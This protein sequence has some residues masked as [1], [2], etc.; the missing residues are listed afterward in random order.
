VDLGLGLEGDGAGF[1][2]ALRVE[3]EL[4]VGVHQCLECAVVGAPLAQVDPVV[5]H[6]DLGVDDGLADRADALGVLEEHLVAIDSDAVG[7]RVHG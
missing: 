5:S 6:V 4:G 2:E 3:V 7:W 1:V